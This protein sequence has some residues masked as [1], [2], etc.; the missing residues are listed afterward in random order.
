MFSQDID[1]IDQ[2]INSIKARAKEKGALNIDIRFILLLDIIR[3]E[4]MTTGKMSD[5]TAGAVNSLFVFQAHEFFYRDFPELNSEC[6]SVHSKIKKYNEKYQNHENLSMPG[7]DDEK[8]IKYFHRSIGTL[9]RGN[10]PS[11]MELD[12]ANTGSAQ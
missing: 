7:V 1:S 8:W 9:I 10:K 12:A 11:I 2:L 5:A 6:S 4:L 3:F